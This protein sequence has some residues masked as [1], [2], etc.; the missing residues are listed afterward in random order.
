MR[1]E[2]EGKDHEHEN[3]IIDEFINEKGSGCQYEIELN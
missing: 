2:P 1:R 3:E